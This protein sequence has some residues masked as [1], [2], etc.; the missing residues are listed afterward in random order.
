MQFTDKHIII[1]YHYIDNARYDRRG[2]HPCPINEFERQVIFL[3][4]IFTVTTIENVFSAA[5]R[6]LPEKMCALTFDD[7]LRDNYINAIP[8]LKKHKLTATFFPIT[9]TFEDFLPATHKIHILL[10]LQN[11]DALIDIFN[12]FIRSSFPKIAGTY[13]IVLQ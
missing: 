12:T 4:K 11:A 7:G 5:C 6:K 13:S 2:I 3:K 9:R 10:S 8:I 1:N